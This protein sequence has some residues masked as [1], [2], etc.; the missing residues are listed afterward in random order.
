MD[1]SEANRIRIK[2]ETKSSLTLGLYVFQKIQNKHNNK[3]KKGNQ[4]Q[5]MG[6]SPVGLFDIG[7]ACGIIIQPKSNS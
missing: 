2:D 5:A 1:R 6:A 4:I 3:K 7:R